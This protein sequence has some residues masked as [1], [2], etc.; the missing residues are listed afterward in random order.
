MG[1]ARARAYV[2]PVVAEQ[3]FTDA[4]GQV[5]D[6]GNRWR[7]T[8]PPDDSYSVESNTERFAPLHTVADALV[9]HLVDA[10]DVTVEDGL[11]DARLQDWGRPILRAVRLTPTDP[12]AASVLIAWTDY[13]GVALHAG[14]LLQSSWPV[15]GCDA[16]DDS[17]ELLADEIEH[18]VLA[19]ATGGFTERIGRASRQVVIGR[20]DKAMR[21]ASAMAVRGADASASASGLSML[22]IPDGTDLRLI[23]TMPGPAA[24]RPNA[25]KRLAEA[26]VA[27]PPRP[28]LEWSLRDGDW[29]TGSGHAVRNVE[30]SVL[31][32]Y[33]KRLDALDGPW[34]PWPA[35]H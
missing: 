10:Y 25:L 22:E 34:H 19:V 8:G 7:L 2:R 6:Y 26:V 21:D 11:D 9:A 31:K 23:N 14:L 35:R 12:Q 15:C 13:P 27:D 30:P 20:G 3:R 33:R 18:T 29:F 5:I 1:E 4:D 24:R 28:W 16:C 17:W 32:A